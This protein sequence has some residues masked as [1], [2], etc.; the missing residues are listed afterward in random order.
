MDVYSQTKKT[1]ETVF[2]TYQPSL[3]R[4][5]EA[6]TT[7]VTQWTLR[8]VYGWYWMS[9]LSF[10]QLSRWAHRVMADGQV[11]YGG[12]HCEQIGRAAWGF[13]VYFGQSDM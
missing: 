11:A 2:T 4:Q 3:L 12:Y 10:F 8:S 7:W 13:P 1:F 5:E 9:G 6:R